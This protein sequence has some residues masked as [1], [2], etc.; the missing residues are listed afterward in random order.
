MKDLKP[1]IIFEDESLLVLNKPAG[2]VVNRSETTKGKETVQDWIKEKIAFRKLKERTVNPHLKDFY[3]RLGIVHRLDKETSGLLLVAKTFK[4]FKDL[5]AQ[6]KKR[7]VKKKY[8][9]LVH[10]QVQPQEGVIEVSISRSPFDRKKFGVFLKGK[11]S[12]TKYKVL[13]SFQSPLGKFSLLEL[14]PKTGRTHQIR[15]HLKFLGYPIVADERYAGRKR[16]RK[17]RLYCPRH[18]L[19]ASYLSFIHPQSGKKM[20]F[21]LQLPSDLQVA[22]IKSGLS[23]K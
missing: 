8:L 15:V 1:Q 13:D 11:P 5:Q 9:A 7:K 21:R 20:E 12:K 22:M 10:G 3:G 4:V 19:H 23:K 6:F 16:S 18:F 2:M 17:D 14:I